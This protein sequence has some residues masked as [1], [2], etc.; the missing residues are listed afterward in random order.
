MGM[1]RPE[2]VLFSWHLAQCLLSTKH[3]YSNRSRHFSTLRSTLAVVTQNTLVMSFQVEQ[4]LP[5]NRPML[6]QLYDLFSQE[7]T[8]IIWDMSCVRGHYANCKCIWINWND[9]LITVSIAI[10]S[11]LIPR[12][13][14]VV[15][16]ASALIPCVTH[17]V[18]NCRYAAHVN[19]VTLRNEI[20]SVVAVI[21][22]FKPLTSAWLWPKDCHRCFIRFGNNHVRNMIVKH[23]P[24]NISCSIEKALP[25]LIFPAEDISSWFYEIQFESTSDHDNDLT[26]FQH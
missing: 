12:V 1:N 6:T 18:P 13:T 25:I 16:I 4:E 21:E 7:T 2:R 15:V 26:R 14:H 11:A 24:Y 3:D 8:G 22:P 17:V 19:T 23:K 10:A 20:T 9:C 5:R